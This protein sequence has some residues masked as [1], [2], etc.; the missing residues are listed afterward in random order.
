M[1]FS[2]I[3]RGGREH[4]GVGRGGV[5]VVEESDEKYGCCSSTPKVTD[6][7]RKGRGRG[8]EGGHN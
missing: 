7:K 1:V 3:F 8:G 6:S 2:L 5:V 4:S